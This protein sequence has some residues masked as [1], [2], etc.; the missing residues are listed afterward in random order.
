MEQM[1]SILKGVIF[2]MSEENQK[3]YKQAL[4]HHD[5]VLSECSEE[6]K[7]ANITAMLVAAHK[8]GLLD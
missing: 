4:E 7:I 1:I 6:D 5:K 2:E 8:T 3:T